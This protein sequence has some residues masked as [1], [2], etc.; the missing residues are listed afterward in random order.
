MQN[1]TLV[2]GTDCTKQ[3]NAIP[4]KQ[5]SVLKHDKF[6]DFKFVTARVYKLLVRENLLSLC[7]C[8][9]VILCSE[10]FGEV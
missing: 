3:P 4:S 6:P 1:T 2:L 5:K 10:K 7:D 9:N 8:E